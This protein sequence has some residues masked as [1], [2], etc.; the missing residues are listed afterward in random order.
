MSDLTYLAAVARIAELEAELD[1]YRGVVDIVTAKDTRIAELEAERDEN[2]RPTGS[3]ADEWRLFLAE[4]KGALDFVAVQI[5]EAIEA[6]VLSERETCAMYIEALAQ[7][8]GGNAVVY[9]QC[10]AAIR[11]RP[12]P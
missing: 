7:K 2:A 3:N 9:R 5:V 6:A 8:H 11:A 1:D 10:T 4:H 12:A